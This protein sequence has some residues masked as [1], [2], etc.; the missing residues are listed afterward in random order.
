[1]AR[2][3]ATAAERRE[4]IIRSIARVTRPLLFSLLIILASF[5]PVYFLGEREARLFEPLAFSKT[6][7]MVFSTLL[8]LFLL[9]IIIVW[10][11]KPGA[12]REHPAEQ[13]LRRVYRSLVTWTIRFRYPFVL[14]NLALLGFALWVASD[15]RTDYM[16]E[17]EEGSI[18]YMPT[19]L[20]G[21]PAREAGWILQRM[22]ARLKAFPEVARVFGKL[23]RADTSTDPA[24]VTMIETTILLKPKAQ[25]RAGMTKQKL[26]AD[27]DEAMKVVG[28]VNTWVQPINARVMMQGTGIQTPVGVKIRGDN[29]ETI[30]AL[31]QKV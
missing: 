12:P 18:L 7:A 28:Y 14:A 8:T 9:P 1:A 23:G 2:P 16:P 6:S 19:T 27:M 5:L 3:A 25:W 13:T 31:G 4:V 15:F 11:F 17:L 22:D 30:D 24:P 21:I 20:P 26:V 10:V 29:V